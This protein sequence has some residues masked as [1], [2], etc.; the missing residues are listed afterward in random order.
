MPALVPSLI[1]AG[2]PDSFHAAFALLARLA[3]RAPVYRVSMPD[4]MS[5]AGAATA[6]LLGEI[7]S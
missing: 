4:G 7:T 6:A 5:R 2:G 3:E 1:H